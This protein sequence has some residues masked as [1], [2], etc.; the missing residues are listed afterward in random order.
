MK[1]RNI[2]FE[3]EKWPVRSVTMLTYSRHMKSVKVLKGLYCG[4][5][6][7]IIYVEATRIRFAEISKRSVSDI[8]KAISFFNLRTFMAQKR[9]QLWRLV[10]EA[11]ASNTRTLCRIEGKVRMRPI[12]WEKSSPKT[13]TF[14]RSIKSQ[15]FNNGTK[16]NFHLDSAFR[17]VVLFA[18]RPNNPQI[19][20]LVNKNYDNKAFQYYQGHG[21]LLERR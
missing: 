8:W 2:R 1:F 10:G 21:A 9:L 13:I 7:W 17:Q 3:R 20:L 15:N 5:E 6:P 12:V 16:L 19:S 4:L 18:K 11:T 14:N